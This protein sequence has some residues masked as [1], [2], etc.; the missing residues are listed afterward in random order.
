MTIDD[1]FPCPPPSRLINNVTFHT[2]RYKILNTALKLTKPV[3]FI[4]DM[5]FITNKGVNSGY[6]KVKGALEAMFKISAAENYKK[7]K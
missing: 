1:A 2:N 6:V 3:T 4:P 5:C 7:P